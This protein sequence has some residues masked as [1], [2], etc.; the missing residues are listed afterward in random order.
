MC[1]TFDAADAADAA[2]GED[3]ENSTH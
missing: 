3:V 1:N 2:G